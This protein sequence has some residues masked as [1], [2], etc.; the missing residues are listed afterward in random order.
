MADRTRIA[1][2]DATWNVTTG[3]SPVSAGCDHCYAVRSA[4]RCRNIAA[5]EG[6]VRDGAWTGRVNLLYDRL[7]AP[8]NR[9]RP[10]RIFVCST[11]D[12][13]TPA[14]P[15]QFLVEVFAVMAICPQH[16][17]Q[18][19][20]KRPRRMSSFLTNVDPGEVELAARHW[21]A[22]RKE[23]TPHWGP[24]DEMPWPLPN[25]WAG[26]S[27]EDDA[28]AF[29]ARHLLST[30]AS[31]RWISAEPLLGP[32][33]GLDLSGVDWLVVGGESGP[34]ARRMSPEW[35]RDLRERCARSGTAFFFKQAGAVLGR[36]WGCAHPAGAEI[37]DVPEEFRVRRYPR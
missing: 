28:Y 8:V 6:L 9:S 5:Y 35:V 7:G 36:E 2:T 14:V 20:T 13:F 21:R 22:G 17:F 31:V 30:P 15:T 24:D 32:L 25:L 11:S 23:L 12:L 33:P 34:G 19:L 16:Q 18:I 1:W 4:S 37:E 27:I 3:C 10:R 26:V 29:R